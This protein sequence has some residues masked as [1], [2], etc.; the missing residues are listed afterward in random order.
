MSAPSRLGHE[1]KD[2]IE[3]G[4]S[5]PPAYLAGATTGGSTGA[6]HA[7]FG[8]PA[9]F[10]K[11]L[12]EA[13]VTAIELRSVGPGAALGEARRAVE[14]AQAAG[15]QVTVHGRLPRAVPDA[16]LDLVYP[17][18]SALRDALSAQGSQRPLTLH[19]YSAREDSVEELARRT[20]LAL[21]SL[22]DALCAAGLP[23]HVALETNHVSANHDPGV[24]YAGIVDMIDRVDRPG[25]GACWDLGHTTMNVQHGQMARLPPDAFLERVIH[26]HVHD[27]GPRTHHPLTHGVVPV[28][29][30]LDLLLDR[31]YDGI[32]NLELSPQRFPDTVCDGV[33]ASIERLVAYRQPQVAATVGERA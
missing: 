20:V 6:W 1:G 22:L 13:G 2:V 21:R 32:L 10:L 29:A 19:C 7:A 11:A 24:T 25:I 3:I 33:W 30:Y 17:L 12:R 27:L 4:L 14:R 5:L 16:G 26:T 9:P 8:P 15:M 28:D 18:L 23:L 31:G